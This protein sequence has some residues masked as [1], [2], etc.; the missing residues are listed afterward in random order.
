MVLVNIGFHTQKIISPKVICNSGMH[1]SG[2]TVT[3][4][5]PK[6]KTRERSLTGLEV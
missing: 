3:E 5:K 4:L 1:Y 2:P 6:D